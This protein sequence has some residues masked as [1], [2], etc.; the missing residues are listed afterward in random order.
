MRRSLLSPISI[1]IL[2][3]FLALPERGEAESRETLSEA[4]GWLQSY[5]RIDTTN[6]PG[7]EYRGAAFL[8]DVLH[9]EG[10]QTQLLVTPEGRTSLYAR[11]EA[12]EA[13]RTG[14]ALLLMH[15]IDVVPA[16]PGWKHPPFDGV[17]E[18][19]TLWGRGAIDVKSLGVAQLTAFIELKRSGLPLR[20]D[21]IYLAAADE[22]SGGGR[23][24]RWLLEHHGELFDQV[25]VVLNEGGLNFTA[26]GNLLWW[27]LEVGQ[28]RP[29]WL[30]VSAKGRAGHASSLNPHSASHKLIL[31]LDRLLAME[32]IYHVSDG[33][34]IYMEALAPLHGGKLGA[35]MAQ[36][37]EVIQPDGPTK[38]LMPGMSSLF[39][40]TV[41]VTRLEASD[42][43]NTIAK[44]ATAEIDIRLLPDTDTEV[45]LGRIR[46]ALGAGVQVEV[47]LDA[48][49]G[50]PSPFDTPLFELI[51]SQ[52][53][54]EAP[55]V[56]AFISGFTDS[57]YF[58]QRG[59]PAYGFSP[60]VLPSTQLKGIHASDEHI[61][62]LEFDRGVQRL[63]KIVQTYAVLTL[64]GL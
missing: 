12:K 16:G 30:R 42:R 24:T 13:E 40:D 31:A 43:I 6:P 1:F 29:L 64:D 55:V 25:G 57:R 60:F 11:L 2:T 3:V 23:G 58:R 54:P 62:L 15:H 46:E 9:Q 4:A 44:A 20:R 26:A 52:L 32:P 61:S 34:R 19:G 47:L 48:P 59:I 27:G 7:N 28:K 37:D 17:V 50:S 51:K 53:S 39:L 33:A 8:A 63:K 22:E 49:P 38:M 5:L 36:I 21:V 41:Q 14:K 56:P 35:N 45:F 18:D 10:I